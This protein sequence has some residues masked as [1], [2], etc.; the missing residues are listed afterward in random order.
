[1]N[2]H[3]RK[4]REKNDRYIYIYISIPDVLCVAVLYLESESINCRTL[5][6]SPVSPQPPVLL[7]DFT[8]YHCYHIFPLLHFL[9][10][11]FILFFFFLSKYIHIS[12]FILSD[13]F[14]P[15]HSPPLSTLTWNKQTK[16][17]LMFLQ[18][19]ILPITK[20]FISPP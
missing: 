20:I 8:L 5:T 13:V 7:L 18:I 15:T 14:T 4:V 16:E 3:N 12:Y 19:K 1:M 2:E 9:L 6:P 11:S 10:L 17:H